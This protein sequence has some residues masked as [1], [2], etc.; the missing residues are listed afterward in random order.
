MPS[1]A[2]GG[3]WSAIVDFLALAI[4][5]R[6]RQASPDVDSIGAIPCVGHLSVGTLEVLCIADPLYNQHPH[7][8]LFL[9]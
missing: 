5:G 9:G 8:F 7:P 4:E 3:G 6:Q 1:R 2:T